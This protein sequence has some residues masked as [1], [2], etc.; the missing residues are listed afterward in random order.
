MAM[1]CFILASGLAMTYIVCIGSTA[2]FVIAFINLARSP[3]SKGSIVTFSFFL[4]FWVTI[5][6]GVCT[7]MCIFI[8]QQPAVRRCLAFAHGALRGAGRLLC[9]PC[10]CARARRNAGSALPQ[11]LVQTE[12]HMS[13]LAREPPVHGGARVA[14]AYD[15]PAYEQ[16]EGGGGS[17]CAVCLG[18]VEKGNAVKRLPVCMH[19]FHQ[20]CV[21]PWLHQHSTCPV[22]RCNLFAPLPA[23]MV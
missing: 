13:V 6:A 4:I 8:F 17:E 2:M 20:Q 18:E 9:P 15:I 22:C 12:S 21:D 16:P 7:V 23:Q 5:V 1:E 10:R 11:F 19:M 14:T 3:H